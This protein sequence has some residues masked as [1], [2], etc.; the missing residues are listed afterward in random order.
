MGSIVTP[1]TSAGGSTSSES[2]APVKSSMYTCRY[3]GASC[4]GAP[5]G[6]PLRRWTS[7]RR[8]AQRAAAGG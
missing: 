5:S 2:A 3:R 4:A 8:A 7:A 6:I 1:A